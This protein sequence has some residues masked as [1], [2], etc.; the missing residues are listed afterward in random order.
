MRNYAND[1]FTQIKG[2]WQRL[3]TG[4]RF[5]VSAVTLA[6][7]AGLA[8]IVWFAGRPSYQTVYTA[9]GADDIA[10]VQRALQGA[11]VT[12]VVGDDGRSFRVDSTK[13]GQAQMAI[14]AA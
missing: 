8:A 10:Q 2:I 12:Y 5:V 1:V 4:Q 3:D 7:V 6:T 13:L 9:Q 11:G 14:T